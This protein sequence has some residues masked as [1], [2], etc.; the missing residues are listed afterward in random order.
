[1]ETR[2]SIGFAAF[3]KIRHSGLISVAADATAVK[4]AYAAVPTTMT[5]Y[6]W[7]AKSVALL[8]AGN[9]SPTGSDVSVKSKPTAECGQ[10]IYWTDFHDR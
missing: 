1:L 8:S 4:A 3:C 5:T 10:R 2:T 9:P 7:M 6:A